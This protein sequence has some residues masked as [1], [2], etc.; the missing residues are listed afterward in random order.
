M[1]STSN[2]LDRAREVLQGAGLAFPNIPA[3]LAGRVREVDRWCFSTRRIRMSPYNIRYWVDAV[4][5][6]GISE[7]A[8]VAH[9][10]HG[11]NSYALHYFLDWKSL[12]LFLQMPWGGAYMD[13]EACK[14]DIARCFE[15]ADR[16]CALWGHAREPAAGKLYIIGSGFYG[17]YWT[18]PGEAQRRCRRW[19]EAKPLLVLQQA[20]EWVERQA[21]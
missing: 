8:V 13:N 5:R 16:L 21:R 7:W 1:A 20:L 4:R 2:G 6:R 12:R 10:G 15:S 3:E 14:E 18:R 9:Q 17:S 11:V 19:P